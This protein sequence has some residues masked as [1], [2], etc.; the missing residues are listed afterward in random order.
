[1]GTAQGTGGQ[2]IYTVSEKTGEI[3]GGA[4]QKHLFCGEMHRFPGILA[5]YLRIA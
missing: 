2:R 1:M 4:S 5:K 3:V